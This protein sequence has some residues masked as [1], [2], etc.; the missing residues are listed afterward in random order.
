MSEFKRVLV[1]NRGEIAVRIIRACRDLGIEPVAV[2]SAGEEQALHVRLAD[3]AYLIESDGR[4]PYLNAVAIVDVAKRSGCDAIHP[5]YGFLAEN[6]DFAEACASAGIVFVG[7]SASSIRAMGDKIV[8]RQVAANAGVPLIPGSEGAVSS[9][10]EAM[11]WAKE[12][13]YPI[14]VKASAGGGGRGF[15]VACGEDELEGAFAGSAGEADRYFGNAEV[16]LERYLHNPRHIEVQLLADCLGNTIWLGERDCSI[17]RRHQKLVEE[18]PSPTVNA[19]MRVALGE[20]AVRLARA[21]DYLGAGTV[22]FMLTDD[23]HFYFLE[24]NTRIQVEHTITEEVTG[25]DLVKEQIRI[26]AGMPLTVQQED[27]R[28]SGHSIQCR[29]NAEDPGSD[30]SPSPGTLT[31]FRPPL[32]P[33]IRVDTGMET[34]SSILPAYDSMIAKVVTW[35]RDRSEAIATMSRALE[36]FRIEGVASTVA[37]HRNVMKH[38]AFIAGSATTSFLQMYPEVLP[39]ERHSSDAALADS[40]TV[41]DVLVEVNGRRLNVR[42]HNEFEFRGRSQNGP[43]DRKPPRSRSRSAGQNSTSSNEIVSPLQGTILRVEAHAGDQVRAGDLI[44]VVEAMKMEN[45]ITAHRDGTVETLDVQSGS[46]VTVGSR[47]ATL[48]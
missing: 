6:G 31:A 23:S 11:G 5:G 47:I 38:P 43:A 2:Y 39:A 48:R 19:D 29:I 41:R 15:R 37:F 16:Y 24:M 32:G 18:C 7:P 4:L 10:E 1:A 13:G 33:R 46:Q 20:A 14:A 26:A 21:V 40:A 9:V 35:G 36:E 12:H 3:D 34:G 25:I 28:I 44:C 17:Q 30:F 22:E 8:A 42:L 27:V 45:E